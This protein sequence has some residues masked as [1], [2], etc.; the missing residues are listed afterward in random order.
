MFRI[1]R[2]VS[3]PVSEEDSSS[4]L[5]DTPVV[6]PHYVPCPEKTK[7]FSGRY[8]RQRDKNKIRAVLG[9]EKG[10]F[11]VA[12]TLGPRVPEEVAVPTES[13]PI[14]CPKRVA[15][16]PGPGADQDDAR[17]VV[18]CMDVCFHQARGQY[19]KTH[20]GFYDSGRN[21]KRLEVKESCVRWVYYKTHE[22][23]LCGVGVAS[24]DD[25]GDEEIGGDDVTVPPRALRRGERDIR[26]LASDGETT[27]VVTH[28][29]FRGLYESQMC[30]TLYL[31]DTLDSLPGG[32]PDRGNL[33]DLYEKRS[34]PLVYAAYPFLSQVSRYPLDGPVFLIEED[35]E[36]HEKTVCALFKLIADQG[37]GRL[38]KL[39][40]RFYRGNAQTVVDFALGLAIGGTPIVAGIFLNGTMREIKTRPRR[41]SP[42]VS[43][44]PKPYIA[45]EYYLS[46]VTNRTLTS[47]TPLLEFVDGTGVPHAT[48]LYN[49]SVLITY[50]GIRADD[51][52]PER[53]S[54]RISLTCAGD[55]E[56]GVYEVT[57]EG[58]RCPVKIQVLPYPRSPDP[59]V[60]VAV[61][62]QDT[63]R[64][65]VGDVSATAGALPCCQA[66][67]QARKI[68]V[69]DFSFLDA[70][71]SQA[72]VFN[73]V[74]CG[75]E[76]RRAVF[77][78]LS[79]RVTAG[80]MVAF[81][82]AVYGNERFCEMSVLVALY[83]GDWYSELRE[84]REAHVDRL[85]RA[86]PVDLYP[87]R[88]E[89]YTLRKA[90]STQEYRRLQ[91]IHYKNIAKTLGGRGFVTIVL[92]CKTI[93]Y[94][95][96]PKDGWCGEDDAKASVELCR[97]IAADKRNLWGEGE[98]FER[99]KHL[100][101]LTHD[102][103][104]KAEG[105]EAKYTLMPA[106][107]PPNLMNIAISPKDIANEKRRLSL[108][109][110]NIDVG[111]ESDGNL[112]RLKDRLGHKTVWESGGAVNLQLRQL[113]VADPNAARAA[114]WNADVLECIQRRLERQKWRFLPPSHQGT[115][116]EDATGYFEQNLTRDFPHLVDNFVRDRT[117]P[118]GFDG[119]CF[120]CEREKQIAAFL[121]D[122]E[123]AY[124]DQRHPFLGA[125]VFFHNVESAGQRQI[126]EFFKD[127]E[128]FGGNALATLTRLYE[129]IHGEPVPAQ[130][131][132]ELSIE[133]KRCNNIFVLHR[134]IKLG[135][136]AELCKEKQKNKQKVVLATTLD[137]ALI[138]TWILRCVH[139]KRVDFGW[140]L[141]WNELIDR[142]Y[143]MLYPTIETLLGGE[144]HLFFSWNLTPVYSSKEDR[145]GFSDLM[146]YLHQ[147]AA[148]H[149]VPPYLVYTR[150][151]SST[152]FSLPR[153][154]NDLDLRSICLLFCGMVLC[155]DTVDDEGIRSQALR[156]C[157]RCIFPSPLHSEELDEDYEGEQLLG[158]VLAQYGKHMGPSVTCENTDQRVS[159]GAKTVP[160]KRV[161]SASQPADRHHPSKAVGI[162]NFPDGRELILSVVP[163]GDPWL[164]WC[165]TDGPLRTV[166]N[167]LP[168]MAVG[169]ET[170]LSVT[171]AVKGDRATVL[172]AGKKYCVKPSRAGKVVDAYKTKETE[173]E[174]AEFWR[175]GVDGKRDYMHER[176]FH[177]LLEAE[178]RS[179]YALSRKDLDHV[180]NNQA[181]VRRKLTQDTHGPTDDRS[182]EF[183][184]EKR[185]LRLASARGAHQTEYTFR[186]EDGP[187]TVP[188]E[189]L[190]KPRTAVTVLRAD[191]SGSDLW[192]RFARRRLI[193]SDL[194]VFS[195]GFTI[196]CMQELDSFAE[197]RLPGLKSP[198]GIVVLYDTEKEGGRLDPESS[199]DK[200]IALL[201]NHFQM[202]TPTTSVENA[203]R[204]EKVSWE[205]HEK[206]RKDRRYLACVFSRS[207]LLPAVLKALSCCRETVILSYGDRPV[208]AELCLLV[209]RLSVLMGST[210]RRVRLIAKPGAVHG[211][212][213][214]EHQD[215]TNLIVSGTRENA[216]FA[217]RVPVYVHGDSADTVARKQLLASACYRL[218]LTT[219]FPQCEPVQ[220]ENMY[221]L[222]P[223]QT[224]TDFQMTVGEYVTRYARAF[225]VFIRLH[226]EETEIHVRRE[227]SEKTFAVYNIKPRALP[228]I[229]TSVIGMEETERAAKDRRPVLKQADP[230]NPTLVP[231]KGMWFS[232]LFENGSLR[233]P[234]EEIKMGE[235]AIDLLYNNSM[236]ETQEETAAAFQQRFKAVGHVEKEA[237][238]TSTIVGRI[239]GLNFTAALS[240]LLSKETLLKELSLSP[241]FEDFVTTEGC[242]TF[243]RPER[244]AP[245]I[246]EDV[247][248]VCVLNLEEKEKGSEKFPVC[249]FVH[250]GK[251]TV[252]YGP[253]EFC[254]QSTETPFDLLKLERHGFER[255]S[256]DFV[257]SGCD[258]PTPELRADRATWWNELKVFVAARPTDRRHS[259]LLTSFSPPRTEAE[260]AL[261]TLLSLLTAAVL[262]GGSVV[263]ILPANE[264]RTVSVV[265]KMVRCFVDLSL[266]RRTMPVTRLT[267][268]F[269]SALSRIGVATRF[270]NLLK[271]P[272]TRPFL[273]EEAIETVIKAMVE[274][275]TGVG[276]NGSFG[277]A[278]T[279][280]AL[281]MA[282]GVVHCVEQLVS[283]ANTAGDATFAEDMG[284]AL[285]VEALGKLRKD[286][287]DYSLMRNIMLYLETQMD[288]FGDKRCVAQRLVELAGTY[289]ALTARANAV[290]V[291]NVTRRQRA[292]FTG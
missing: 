229:V 158:Q 120:S 117:A 279:G 289:V 291:S 255:E 113:A 190:E 244:N 233:D 60:S 265:L 278:H 40:L 43:F 189:V 248:K 193:S 22:D 8:R 88:R 129:Q 17:D 5:S 286:K 224:D 126:I 19:H 1:P 21:L 14:C 234:A 223:I 241:S 263:L 47:W 33:S 124:F 277:A 127:K 245:Q 130:E 84:N 150:S 179:G 185:R 136:F 183:C 262:G 91:N 222:V 168:V 250:R 155:D 25:E 35:S 77:E 97:V 115:H 74:V 251:Q 51:P 26:L 131:T 4:D 257:I 32:C 138:L 44:D 122:H 38:L 182:V 290:C 213:F 36:Q 103:S 75:G 191:G 270:Y 49:R 79:P 133:R 67:L 283:A 100:M 111:F 146:G 59:L 284:R 18:R 195:Q 153:K 164:V 134:M 252:V 66:F 80:E 110:C 186:L 243:V 197:L 198:Y 156:L 184:S 207:G 177:A 259:V 137:E 54:E 29:E 254:F 225:V 55:P 258:H 108:W 220:N 68:I 238:D 235:D 157:A 247:F 239:N 228:F 96:P 178:S 23:I 46:C 199:I 188:L 204:N 180:W 166:L 264:E 27:F 63:I 90:C 172:E 169:T 236:P 217:A 83:N 85:F 53:C 219:T 240:C 192:Q 119:S 105:G 285:C 72:I 140:L 114:K 20:S 282:F 253:V 123:A 152:R 65:L 151:V 203:K 13:G 171:S 82:S 7:L 62:A 256:V 206:N 125:S 187:I 141:Q 2:A 196:V 128:R 143:R 274:E 118:V 61:E 42:R 201:L 87:K 288:R 31:S 142:F 116:A 175:L 94:F 144:H 167:N 95:D 24:D 16:D 154:K 160:V 159:F 56:A 161:S 3:Q 216:A 272:G 215:V 112:I 101:L 209:S 208:N 121:E 271:G 267:F 211:R 210:E 73:D 275:E 281:E 173:K 64:I 261:S 37:P 93:D 212:W 194:Y 10:M 249:E 165:T 163:V 237:E 45:V 71:L 135:Q 221:I 205:R 76:L 89:E 102:W 81:L 109:K 200:E 69:P 70:A 30:K 104:L 41:F 78:F 174:V 273:K 176:C 226:A 232:L 287:K 242:L 260:I 12:R 58:S 147:T 52:R 107:V 280:D 34:L 269:Q 92:E 145:M 231:H 266:R 139:G 227:Q 170:N 28:C 268:L 214:Q 148:I 230:V 202:K 98:A 11:P 57:A 86:S 149:L 48:F 246:L 106:Y 132:F 9:T 276:S 15:V 39:D 6:I 292:A 162:L 99:Y 181:D 218:V 50:P